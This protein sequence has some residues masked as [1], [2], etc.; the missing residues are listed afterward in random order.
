ME[1]VYERCAGLYVHNKKIL[2]YVRVAD[3]RRSV[4]RQ[5]KS[6]GTTMGDLV[7]LSDWLRSHAVTHVAME[8]TGIFWKPVYAIL[9]GSFILPHGRH[10]TQGITRVRASIKAGRHERA[11][12]T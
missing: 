8:S 11:M 2:A 5:V 7:V 6:F 10:S 3:Q 1:V 4:G 9:V 12:S